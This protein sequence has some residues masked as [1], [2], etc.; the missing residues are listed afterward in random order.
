MNNRKAGFTL[1]EILV[2]VMIITILATI[3]GVN[4]A[5]EPGRA[6][7]VAAKTQ[8]GVFRQALQMYQMDQGQYPTQEQGLKALC[9]RPQIPPLPAKYRAEGYLDSRNLPKDPWNHDYIYLI[10][11]PEGAPYEIVTYGSDGEI[12]GEGESADISSRQL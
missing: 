5:K 3:V 9:E 6:R 10:P 4:V 12:G 1:L 7:V 8:I 2:V 11:G